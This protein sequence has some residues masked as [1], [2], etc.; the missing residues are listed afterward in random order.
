M[1]GFEA[2]VSLSVISVFPAFPRR[3]LKREIK[4]VRFL[5]ITFLSIVRIKFTGCLRAGAR[6]SDTPF[7]F[8]L[9][10]SP[11]RLTPR[12]S[13]IAAPRLRLGP[14]MDPGHQRNAD[15]SAKSPAKTAV[16]GPSKSLWFIYSLQSQMYFYLAR[17]LLFFTRFLK[18]CIQAL[19]R[20][21]V[22]RDGPAPKRVSPVCRMEFIEAHA[23]HDAKSPKAVKVVTHSTV[24]DIA[25]K[26]PTPKVSFNVDS[27][28]SGPSMGLM[29]WAR[30]AFYT[31]QPSTK[32]ETED[33]KPA[34]DLKEKLDFGGGKRGSA[35]GV[36]GNRWV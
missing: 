11:T 5:N 26:S 1:G 3:G 25:P 32:T 7:R 33:P 18:R 19:K 22:R 15:G 30:W 4:S 27:A 12:I 31:K 2:V 10:R 21:F 34:A 13:R 16:K 29:G 17:S 35:A 14:H 9:D 6:N 24:V 36:G 8:F 23:K 28:S 20:P